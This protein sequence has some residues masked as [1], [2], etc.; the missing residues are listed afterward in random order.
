MSDCEMGLNW[1]KTGSNDW[2]AH[3][4]KPSGCTTVP[5]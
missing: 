4:C 2:C 1:I 5:S 3:L